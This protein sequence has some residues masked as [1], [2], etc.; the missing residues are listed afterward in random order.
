MSDRIQYDGDT[1]HLDEIVINGAMVHLERMSQHIWW[2]AIY[3]DGHMID[4]H[5]TDLWTDERD[6]F[7]ALVKMDPPLLGCPEEWGKHHHRH[8]CEVDRPG[9]VVHR[10]ECGSKRRGPQKGAER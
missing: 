10:C 4:L 6:G 8:R 3:R 2:G 1:D 5:F 7:D 9:H